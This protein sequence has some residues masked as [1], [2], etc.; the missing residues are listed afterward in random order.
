MTN[1]ESLPH[2]LIIEDEK[3]IRRFLN[4]ALQAENMRVFEAETGQQG[5][6]EASTR[7]PDLLIIDLGL[8]DREG[9]E[10]IR[11]IRTWSSAPIIVLS[12]RGNRKRFK[13]WTPTTI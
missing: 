8:P 13:Y 5:L 11:E 6:I 1:P 3:P 10:V 12:A 2:I 4:T 7:E 9:I